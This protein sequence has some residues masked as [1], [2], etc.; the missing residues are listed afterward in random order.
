METDLFTRMP[1]HR[2]LRREI[3]DI[4]RPWRR[5]KPIPVLPWKSMMDVRIIAG[6][7]RSR[8]MII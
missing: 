7:A 5:S 4:K 2:H 6:K 1:L 8:F 3:F